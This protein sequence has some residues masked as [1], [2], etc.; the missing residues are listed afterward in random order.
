M[1]L[2][3]CHGYK[4]SKKKQTK[5][6]TGLH[7]GSIVSCEDS[8]CIVWQSVVVRRIGRECLM[9]YRNF[10]DRWLEWVEISKKNKIMQLKPENK[11]RL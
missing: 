5:H 10:N 6:G 7:E 11:N 2:E 1:C 9:Q 8:N 3:L 4:F